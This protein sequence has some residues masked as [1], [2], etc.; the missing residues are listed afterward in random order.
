MR[1]GPTTLLAWREEGLAFALVGD[2]D[3]KD[4]VRIAISVVP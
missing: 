1:D 2:L 4:L 3:L